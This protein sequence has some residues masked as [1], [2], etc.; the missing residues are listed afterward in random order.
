MTFTLKA[1]PRIHQMLEINQR[2]YEEAI[3]LLMVMDRTMRIEMI[4]GIRLKNEILTTKY[5]EITLRKD[6]YNSIRIELTELID[7][8]NDHVL[9]PS[10]RIYEIQSIQ[11]ETILQTAELYKY[12]SKRLARN[13]R[14]KRVQIKIDQRTGGAYISVNLHKF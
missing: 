10:R 13:H 2:T 11:T 1:Q 5:G 7:I 8:L 3:E 4:E 14:I 9:Y 12:I 6:G